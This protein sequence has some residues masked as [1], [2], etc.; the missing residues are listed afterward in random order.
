MQAVHPVRLRPTGFCP[1][2]TI[3]RVL[4]LGCG[5]GSTIEELA[6]YYEAIAVGIDLDFELLCKARENHPQYQFF[7]CSAETLPFSSKAFSHVDSGVALPYMDVRKVFS[8]VHRVLAPGGTFRFSVHNWWFVV[9]E[10]RSARSMVALAYRSYVFLNGL[11]FHFLG[12]Q[13]RFLWTKRIESFQTSSRI[14]RELYRV[15][16]CD[17]R[18]GNQSPPTFWARRP[19]E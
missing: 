15:G 8:E 1:D 16:F 14:R 12:K 10:F 13:F 2:C 11:L 17:V 5:N 9:R 6:I 4:D 7:Q 18:E 19:L 3:S